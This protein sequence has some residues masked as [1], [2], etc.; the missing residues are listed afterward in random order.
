MPS[1]LRSFSF[2]FVYSTNSKNRSVVPLADTPENCI[3]L[4]HRRLSRIFCP[5]DDETGRLHFLH[6][7]FPTIYPIYRRFSTHLELNYTAQ[8]IELATGT[9]DV[10]EHQLCGPGV[11]Y[12]AET[13][14]PLSD[15][16]EVVG[17]PSPEST[18]EDST[19][20]FAVCPSYPLSLPRIH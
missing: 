17:I 18:F 20:S 4:S 19:S 7:L 6:S 10:D 16:S 9:M 14:V 5:G 3:E 1:A 11:T 2:E 12:L 13:R 15:L 8:V